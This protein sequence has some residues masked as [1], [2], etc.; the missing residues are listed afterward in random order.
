MAVIMS[1]SARTTLLCMFV[2]V[3]LA[4][5]VRESNAQPSPPRALTSSIFTDETADCKA[6]EELLDLC[7]R[8]AKATRSKLAYPK[9]CSSDLIA[10]KWCYDFIYFTV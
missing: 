1:T 9:C 2:V 3:C 7:Q 6:D 8:C 10:R 5:L 4:M